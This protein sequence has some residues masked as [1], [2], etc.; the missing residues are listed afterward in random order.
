MGCNV[1]KAQLQVADVSHRL[2][3]NPPPGLQQYLNKCMGHAVSS[4]ELSFLSKLFKDLASRSGGE[5]VD[6]NTFLQFFPLP[7]SSTQGLWGERLF[8]KFDKHSLNSIGFEEFI[9]G[10]SICARG[11]DDEKLHFLFELYDLRG[12]G[13]LDKEELVSMVVLNSGA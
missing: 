6:K 3:E 9:E 12:D 8:Q 5:T 7:V 10:L 13:L 2:L 1:N 11:S 4:H